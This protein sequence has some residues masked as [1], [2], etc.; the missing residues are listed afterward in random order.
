MAL[1]L[2]S[3]ARSVQERDR[4]DPIAFAGGIPATGRSLKSLTVRKG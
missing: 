1:R 4:R 3:S 2:A